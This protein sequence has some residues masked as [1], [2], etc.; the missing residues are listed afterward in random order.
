MGEMTPIGYEVSKVVK[1]EGVE[2]GFGVTGSYHT[3]Y[4]L[5]MLPRLGIQTYSFRHEQSGAY[6]ADGYT[7][8]SRKVS[9]CWGT[10]GPGITNAVS[11]VAQA[12]QNMRPMVFFAGRHGQLVNK[13]W[14]LQESYPQDLFKSISKWVTNIGD[15]RVAPYEVRKAFKI[16]KEFPQGP[17]VVCCSPTE[18]GWVLDKDTFA[19]FDIPRE[20]I[21]DWP[22][23]AGDPAMVERAVD[24]LLKAE[25]PFLICGDGAFYA[26][27][28]AEI[29][30][31][32]EL[33][34]IR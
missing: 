17:C 1:E 5:V 25:R 28:D 22:H 31:F 27:A 3:E 11:G 26:E 21:A 10:A 14:S 20:K 33:L 34:Q 13:H 8:C 24:R 4:F 16:A 2:A 6:A 30:E 23:A 32:C 29:K 15:G 9:A 19:F 18:G 7:G 12:Y